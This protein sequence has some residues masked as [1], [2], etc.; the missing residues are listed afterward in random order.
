VTIQL[1]KIKGLRTYDLKLVFLLQNVYSL[2]V[3]L[4]KQVKDFLWFFQTMTASPTEFHLV[5]RCKPASHPAWCVLTCYV[6]SR[7]PLV[8]KEK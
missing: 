7:D 3:T 5:T 2:V 4:R 6:T 8:G 1:L